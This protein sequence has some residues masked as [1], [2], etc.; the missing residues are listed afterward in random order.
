MNYGSSVHWWLCVCGLGH[1]GL[2]PA[3]L[4]SMR[5]NTYTTGNFNRK[6]YCFYNYI[7]INRTDYVYQIEL[8]IFIPVQLIENANFNYL[9]IFSQLFN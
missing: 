8:L 4:L 6:S 2:I 1:Y 5:V 3:D 7:A 9:K